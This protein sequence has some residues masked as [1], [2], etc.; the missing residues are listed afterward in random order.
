MNKVPG[1]P[2]EER[3]LLLIQGCRSFDKGGDTEA[4]P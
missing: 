1:S 2:E 3:I 4:R